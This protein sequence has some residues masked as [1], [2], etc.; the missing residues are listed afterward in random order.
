MARTLKKQG[1]KA[2][3]SIHAHEALFDENKTGRRRFVLLY[4]H[5]LH[6]Y[7]VCMYFC[8]QYFDMM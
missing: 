5:R 8:G 7:R 6:I 2:S 1:I 3:S 4:G